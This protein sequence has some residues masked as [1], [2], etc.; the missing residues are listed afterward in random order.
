MTIKRRVEKLE[1]KLGGK[2]L[3]IENYIDWLNGGEMPEGEMHPELKAFL[4]SI[5]DKYFEDTEA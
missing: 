3:E 2:Y 1:E 5:P 4:E